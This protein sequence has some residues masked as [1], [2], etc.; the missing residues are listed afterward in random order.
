MPRDALFPLNEGQ[1]RVQ[2]VGLLSALQ[3]QK[4]LP[5]CGH[6]SKCCPQTTERGVPAQ[7]SMCWL[8]V[9]EGLESMSRSHAACW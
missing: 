6:V 9:L 5:A 4:H 8:T 2:I 1:Y 7:G 3:P